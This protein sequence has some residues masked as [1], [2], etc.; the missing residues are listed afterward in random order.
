MSKNSVSTDIR[1]KDFWRDNARFADLANAAIF[2]GRSIIRPESLHELD[3]DM[4]GIVEFKDYEKSLAKLHDVVK[5]TAY[6]IDF[7]I[8]SLENQQDIHYAMPLRTMI[9]DG[10][11][12]LKEYQEIS[13]TYK[14]TDDKNTKE[15]SEE[16]FKDDESIMEATTKVGLEELFRKTL[17]KKLHHDRI[18]LTKEE[19]LSKFRKDDRLH[20]IITIV[21]SYN[22]KPWDGPLTLHDMMLDMSPE[23]DRF[24]LITG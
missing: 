16:V 22:E 14:I 8:L 24:F 6:G 10:L 5:K 13:R 4:S 7:V 17:A 12:Y 11:G 23:M 1:L 9:Y 21:I 18:K 19:Y 3:T 2:D 15:K 20:P